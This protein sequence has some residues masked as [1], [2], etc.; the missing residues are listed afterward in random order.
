M[1]AM[2]QFNE[3]EMVDHQFQEAQETLAEALGIKDDDLEQQAKTNKH[4]KNRI[5]QLLDLSDFDGSIQDD[6]S[7]K[8]QNT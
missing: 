3:D 8:S 1:T 4:T 5:K 7:H 2:D 6:I